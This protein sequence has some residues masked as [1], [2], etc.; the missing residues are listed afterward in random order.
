[1]V[2][3][4]DDQVDKIREWAAQ[5]RYVKEVRLFGSRAKGSARPDSDIDLAITVG[6]LTMAWYEEITLLL[7]RNGSANYPTCSG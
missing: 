7:V 5:T 2:N 1:M 3:L 4:T 6:D